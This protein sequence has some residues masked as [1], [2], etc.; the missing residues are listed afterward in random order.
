MTFR[1][2]PVGKRGHRPSWESQDRRNFYLN[3]AFGL[4]VIAA[5][6]IL[7]IAA[8]LTWYDSHLA[9]V[10]SVDGQN[11][12]KDDFADRLKIESWRIDQADRAVRDLTVAGHIT[13]AQAQSQQQ[14]IEQQ[15]SQISALTLERLIDSKL[16]AELASSEG[17]TATPT[18]VDAALTTEATTKET[19]HAW[20]DRGQARDRSGRPRADGRPDGRREGEGRCGPPR[21]PE[22][23]GLGR[24]RQDGLDRR[25]D[26]AAGRRRRLDLGRQHAGGSDMA[27]GGLRRGGRHA[28]DRHRG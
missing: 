9:S 25:I 20:I 21:P 28:D 23:Q 6:A 2:K 14:L 13:A 19:R 26:R 8:G 24:G 5:V 10:G 7:L 16:Q 3:L 22:R 11:I 17:V 4:V 12:T 1:A 27:Q 15:R 18:D